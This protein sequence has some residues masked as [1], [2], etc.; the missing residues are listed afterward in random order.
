MLTRYVS[1]MLPFCSSEVE[2]GIA[3]VEGRARS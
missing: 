3:A 2:S 1:Y